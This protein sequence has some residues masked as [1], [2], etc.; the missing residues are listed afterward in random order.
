[1]QI[2]RKRHAICPSLRE[3]LQTPTSGARRIIA[4][5]RRR[6]TG[7]RAA[8]EHQLTIMWSKQWEKYVSVI[9]YVFRITSDRYSGRG[10]DARVYRVNG[11]KRVDVN[12]E[13]GQR[14]V[15][16]RLEGIRIASCFD[17]PC[18]DRCKDSV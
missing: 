8:V 5:R 18:V 6:P 7:T 14:L 10:V 4:P 17:V 1:V 12:F 15:G 13:V 11:T 3:N 9:V 2:G 16:A